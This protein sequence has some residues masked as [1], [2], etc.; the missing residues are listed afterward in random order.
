MSFKDHF[1]GHA[2]DYARYRPL[3]PEALFQF[4]ASAVPGHALAWDCGTGSGQAALALAGHFTRVIATDPSDAQMANAPS[5]A[6]V[7][8]VHT[9]CRLPGVNA[10]AVDLVS[11]AQALHWFDLE[12]FYAEVR[13]VL[14]PEG[15][16]AAWCYSLPRVSPAMDPLLRR[17]HQEV[18]GPYWPPERR[19]VDTGYADLSFPFK[20]STAPEFSI[21]ADW[22]LDELTGYLGTWSSS[23]CYREARGSDP[24]A[25]VYTAFCEAWGDPSI[26]RTVTWPI[27]LRVGRR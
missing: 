18:I 3:Y 23:K 10:A 1:S 26:K 9:E 7:E 16:I 19:A 20:E 14:R 5:H 24:I 8:Y 21:Q 17:Y 11:V 2:S 12:A 15:V 4:L 22:P 13:R 27:H 25:V 6:R